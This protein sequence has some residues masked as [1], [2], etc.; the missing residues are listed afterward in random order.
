MINKCNAKQTDQCKTD[1]V[2]PYS[3]FFSDWIPR[4]DLLGNRHQSARHKY[5]A[6]T[7]ILCII[8]VKSVKRCPRRYLQNRQTDN[9]TD[10]LP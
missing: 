8:S 4:Q 7:S 6:R 5:L 3:T 9:H 10:K 2:S 1:T